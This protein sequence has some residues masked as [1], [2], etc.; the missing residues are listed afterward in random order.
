MVTLEKIEAGAANYI[1]TEILPSFPSNSL[2]RVL[3]ATAATIALKKSKNIAALAM[4]NK[5]VKAL[6]IFDA[7]G[8]VDV[9]TL[10]S[11]F[12]ANVPEDGFVI[13]IPVIQKEMTFKKSDVEK[14]YKCIAE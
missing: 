14:M 7:E 1:D 9:D 2:N 11:S 10:Y 13:E 12:Y 6:E 3:V 8:N 5:F 4:E